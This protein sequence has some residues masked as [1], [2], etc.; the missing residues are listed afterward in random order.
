M[1]EEKRGPALKTMLFLVLGIASHIS[2][3]AI[4]PFAT[5]IAYKKRALRREVLSLDVMATVAFLSVL[6]IK[7]FYS[8]A[9]QNVIAARGF[10]FGMMVENYLF[11]WGRLLFSSFWIP[12]RLDLIG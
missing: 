10:E 6:A 11:F 9:P 5:Y 12:A 7:T 2:T 3:A 1:D 4:V 8:I